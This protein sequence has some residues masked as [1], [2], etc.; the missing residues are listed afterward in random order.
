LA[1]VLDEAGKAIVAWAER[2]V[3]DTLER[4][5]QEGHCAALVL[6]DAR[7]GRQNLE[8]ALAHDCSLVAL[9][10]AMTAAADDRACDWSQQRADL[11]ARSGLAG[12]NEKDRQMMKTAASLLAILEG[13]PDPVARALVA[14]ALGGR[15]ERAPFTI[16][17][18]RPARV[19]AEAI[20]SMEG[21]PEAFASAF[22]AVATWIAGG[23]PRGRCIEFGE[24]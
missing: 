20:V 11:V 21:V 5:Q 22:R 23:C 8:G 1:S 10:H 16:K 4:L 15:E 12:V 9:A 19:F 18:A 17:G 14:S 24:T 2:D 3:P 13:L 6:H 7:A